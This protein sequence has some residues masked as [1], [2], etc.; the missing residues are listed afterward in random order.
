MYFA[1]RPGPTLGAID[2]TQILKNVAGAVLKG[3]TVTI[4]T[5]TGPIIFDLSD[6]D[7]VKALQQMVTKAQLT[8]GPAPAPALPSI[9]VPG[10]WS[11]VAVVGLVAVLGFLLLSGGARR[12]A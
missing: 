6:P 3:Q 1:E 2:W 9:P 7:Q 11:T 12:S 4:Q 5:P 8:R 10:G